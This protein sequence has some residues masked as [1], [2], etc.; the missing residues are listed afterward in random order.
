M[1]GQTYHAFYTH[2]GP[3]PEDECPTITV[4]VN[5]HVLA[6]H[7]RGSLVD[8]GA[9]G[10]ILGSDAQVIHTYQHTINVTGID[11]HQ[12]T[13]LKIV[14]GAAKAETHKGPVI[15]IM[16]QYAELS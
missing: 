2:V 10:G 11:N 7:E 15:L 8:R 1:N 13:D 6:R 5:Q 12:I 9:N 3:Q 16:R 14:D 4:S